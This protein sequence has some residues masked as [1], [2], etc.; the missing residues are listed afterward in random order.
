[1]ALRTPHWA[2][3]K[4]PTR[5]NS[6]VTNKVSS[7]RKVMFLD[8]DGISADAPGITL[9]ELPADFVLSGPNSIKWH[10]ERSRK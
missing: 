7:I 9:R 4:L 6:E 2:W 1:M 3:F 5:Y 10:A 8:A